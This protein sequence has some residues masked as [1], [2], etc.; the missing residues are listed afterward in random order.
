[1]RQLDREEARWLSLD[2]VWH[3]QHDEDV[4]AGKGGD[5]LTDDEWLYAP[6][7]ADEQYLCDR[8]S[9]LCSYDF[10]PEG[11]TEDPIELESW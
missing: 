1:M 6:L 8:I 2:S 5:A 11:T 4:P 7:T 9:R 10:G 3:A